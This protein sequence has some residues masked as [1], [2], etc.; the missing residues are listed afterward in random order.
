MADEFATIVAELSRSRRVL[1]TTHVRPDGDA[2]GSCAAMALALRRRGTAAEVLL[3]SPPPR[4]Y[5]YILDENGIA[6]F[7]GRSDVPANLDIASFDTLA[8]LDTGTWQQL[9][10]LRQRLAGCTL[11][12]L[13]V[14]HHL[15]QETWGDVRLVRP[16]AAATGQIVADLIDAMNVAID[17]PIAEALYLAL[18]TDTG[19]LQFSNTTPDALRLTARLLEA[20]ADQQR[21]Y[22]L[23]YQSER[24]SR[25]ALQSRAMQ[26]LE[27]LPGGRVAVMTLTRRDFEQ[28]AA[29]DGD[30]ENLINLPLMIESVEVSILV[31]EP[32]D[33]GDIRV[34]LR[35]KSAVDVARFAERFGGGGHA[36]AAGLKLPPPLETARAQVVAQMN[37]LMEQSGCG[38]ASADGACSGPRGCR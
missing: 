9:P 35:S 18:I 31:V 24:L 28:C 30:T 13:V 21:L 11:R 1:L 16:Q 12:V 10:H 33:G 34:S 8:V 7:V 37:R 23:L 36:R 6:P 32:L 2:L 25:F 5:A 20:G 4:K 19:W 27:L 3:L 26:S 15:T 29:D 17:R 22:R 38:A 14:D